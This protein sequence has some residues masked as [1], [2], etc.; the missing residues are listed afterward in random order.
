MYA[1]SAEKHNWGSAAM[2]SYMQI[3]AK[4]RWKTLLQRRGR[5]IGRAIINGV[6][7]FSLTGLL[8]KKE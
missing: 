2:A 1:V 3:P 7:G 8:P 4:Q 5:V 6:D